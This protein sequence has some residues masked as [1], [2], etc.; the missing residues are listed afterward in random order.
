MST[1]VFNENSCEE[2]DLF[3][4]DI[5]GFG[6]MT[7]EE[8]KN[9]SKAI[10]TDDKQKASLKLQ[11][12]LWPDG[13]VPFKMSQDLTRTQ[14]GVIQS[15]IEELERV[16][17]VRFVPRMKHADFVYIQKRKMFCESHV[18]RAGKKQTLGLANGCFKNGIGTVLHELMHVLGFFHEHSRFDRDEFVEV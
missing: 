9:A 8:L 12:N 7:S 1:P 10:A 16:S 3:E 13:V 18:G 17:C 14:R 15:A 6:S 4:G 11:R 2:G 5:L